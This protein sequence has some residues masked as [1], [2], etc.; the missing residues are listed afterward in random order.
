L[1]ARGENGIACGHKRFDNVFWDILG[2][3]EVNE[4]DQKLAGITET[5]CT[6]DR[7]PGLKLACMTQTGRTLD[8]E[9]L[10]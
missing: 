4:D 7:K 6:L 2:N 5:G 3:V 8:R 9:R 1:N 10:A